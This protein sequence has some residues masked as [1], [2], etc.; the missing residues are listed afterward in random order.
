M[1]WKTDIERYRIR[2]TLAE[3]RGKLEEALTLSKKL[4]KRS[5]G[6]STAAN[7]RR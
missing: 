7:H 1:K 5:Y 4:D 3:V 2:R 6:E